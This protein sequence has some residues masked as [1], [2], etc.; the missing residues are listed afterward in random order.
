MRWLATPCF[1]QTHNVLRQKLEHLL[2]AFP[3]CAIYTPC[4]HNQVRGARQP[5]QPSVIFRADRFRLRFQLSRPGRPIGEQIRHANGAV[6]PLFCISDETPN[7][8]I[9]V[10]L[11][12]GRGIEP[13]KH[14]VARIH[15]LPFTPKDISVSSAWRENRLTMIHF[16]RSV[17]AS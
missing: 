15:R 17:L 8:W 7:G 14:D 2:V 13:D 5:H 4:R 6:A 12:R 9:I 11:V 1:T 3:I 16:C 10:H